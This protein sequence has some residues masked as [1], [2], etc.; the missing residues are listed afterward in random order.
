MEEIEIEKSV[1]EREYYNMMRRLGGVFRSRPGYVNAQN[2]IKSL[3]GTAERKNG[4]QVSEYIGESTPFKIQQFIYRG[5]YSA[6]ACRDVLREYITEAIGEEEG[7]L[8][9]DDTGFL[10]K[11]THS[12]G[13]KRQYTGTAGR[14]ENC[15]IG[16]FMSYASSVGHSPIDRRLYIPEEWMNDPVRLGEAGVPESVKFQTKPQM[17]LEMIQEATKAGVPYKWVVGDSAYGDYRGIR[18]WLEANDKCYVL[19][20]S[21]KESIWKDSKKVTVGSVLK[22]LP[23]EKWFEASCGEGSKGAR[24]YDWMIIEIESDWRPAALFGETPE[25]WKRVMLVRRSQTDHD[26]MRAH[27]CYAPVETPNEILIEKAGM[28]WTVESC[29]RESKSEVGMDQYECRSYDGWYR[30]ITFACLALALLTVVSTLSDVA[31]GFDGKSMQQHEPGVG[32]LDE[33]KKKRNLRV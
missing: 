9:V 6:D 26:D 14:I 29:F 20:V 2:Y 1:F 4:W 24:I 23:D 10:K 13:V 7:V 32:T 30:H 5:E 33:F 31:D 19:C 16:V 25:G 18:Q 12:C 11:G 8:V 15:Q 28:R 21:A 22:N 27:I 3:M 17:A